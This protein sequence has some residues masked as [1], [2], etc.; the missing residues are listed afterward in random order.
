MDAQAAGLAEA[1]FGQGNTSS[2]SELLA[3]FVVEVGAV[4][5]GWA[6][7]ARCAAISRSDKNRTER[8]F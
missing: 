3:S 4:T 8:L 1:G 2:L 7:N 6:A 5:D